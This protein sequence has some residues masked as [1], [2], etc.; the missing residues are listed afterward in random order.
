VRNQTDGEGELRLE[1]AERL[2]PTSPAA[3]VALLD[4]VTDAEYPRDV[5]LQA[6]ALLALREATRR[7]DEAL[8]RAAARLAEAERMAAERPPPSTLALGRL[9]HARGYVAFRRADDPA[10]V[11]ALN[12]AAGLLASVPRLQARVFDVLGMLL[13]RQGDL[14][15]ARE[16]FL[17]AISTREGAGTGAGTGTGTALSGWADPHGQAISYGSLGR[18]ELARERGREAEGWLRKDLALLATIE[19]SPAGEAH[20]RNLLA[21][22]IHSQGPMRHMDVKTELD[23]ALALAPHDSIARAYVLKDMAS[24]ALDRG[25]PGEARP[26]VEQVAAAATE[27]G[28]AELSPWLRLLEAR[29]LSAEAGAR[30]QPLAL[31]AFDEAWQGFVQWN[32]PREACEAA[33]AWADA[34][35]KCDEVGRAVEVLERARSLAEARLLGQENPLARIEAALDRAGSAGLVAVLS[36]RLRRLLGGL[37]GAAE[38]RG[39]AAQGRPAEHGAATEQ[40]ASA[41]LGG[42]AYHAHRL[43]GE[44]ALTTVLVC[45]VL[46]ASGLCAQPHEAPRVLRAISRAFAALSREILARGG[47]VDRYAGGCVLA[48]FP[49]EDAAA[50]A[51]QVALLGP[52][53]LAALNAERAHLPEPL[54]SCAASVATGWVVEGEV[55]FSGRLERT[56]LGPP[57][58]LAMRMVAQASV[59]EV[60]IDEASRSALG[61]RFPAS[62]LGRRAAPDGPPLFVLAP[63]VAPAVAANGR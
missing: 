59:G 58:A 24:L 41:A 11:S 45:E 21:L 46:G 12:E 53:L 49:G 7:T 43:S 31:A 63:A 44:Q 61:D 27:L 52:S 35:M 4:D 3:A 14:E 56:L 16:Y 28:F 57:V 48:C 55:G 15:G 23:R 30:V 1:Q 13:T 9:A 26:L 33:L 5:R 50:R 10:A 62:P 60:L 42:R 37:G 40:G 20:V 36:G 34:L 18:L 17:L 39:P 51:A 32:M 47:R 6:A 8:G 22:A 38:Q 19:H 54:L 25:K 29:A 2:L